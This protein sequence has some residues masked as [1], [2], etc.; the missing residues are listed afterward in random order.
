[1]PPVGSIVDRLWPAAVVVGGGDV[2]VVV[3]VIVVAAAV[4]VVV[5][6]IVVVCVCPSKRNACVYVV[7]RYVISRYFGSASPP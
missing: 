7:Q 4:V 2:D 5:V 1:M 6:V 3:V